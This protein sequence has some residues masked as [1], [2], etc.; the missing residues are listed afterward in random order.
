MKRSR[1]RQNPQP[2]PQ[3][4]DDEGG[5]RLLASAPIRSEQDTVGMGWRVEMPC[6]PVCASGARGLLKVAAAQDDQEEVAADD[7]E[8]SDHRIG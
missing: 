3:S 1:S 4:V 2:Q 6:A 5:A 7:R 8:E